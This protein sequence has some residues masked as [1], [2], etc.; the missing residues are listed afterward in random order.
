VSEEPS[1]PVEETHGDEIVQ[2]DSASQA[3]SAAVV[4]PQAEVQ[5]SA[6]EE[7]PAGTKVELPGGLQLKSFVIETP[8]ETNVPVLSEHVTVERRPVNREATGADFEAFE[9]GVIDLVELAEELVVSKKPRVVEEVVIT[10]KV[11]QTTETVR[12]NLKQTH[13]TTTGS[14]GLS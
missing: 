13:L 2:A 7:T 14:S 9:Q 10:K 6:P 1:H 8:V 5:E 3:D 4:E 12:E 11:R